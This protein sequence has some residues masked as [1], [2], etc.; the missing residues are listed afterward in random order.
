MDYEQL[1]YELL[2]KVEKSNENIDK[3]LNR[4]VEQNNDEQYVYKTS[5]RTDYLYALHGVDFL[6]ILWDLDQW[7]RS[8]VK[9]NPDPTEEEKQAFILTRETLYDLMQEKSLSLDM[10]R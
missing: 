7:L 8:Q 3:N 9:Y 10:L 1:Y 2:Q 4:L 6:L 5:D